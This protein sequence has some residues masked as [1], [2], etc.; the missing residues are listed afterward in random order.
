MV[1]IKE[2]LQHRDEWLSFI[3]ISLLCFACYS[4]YTVVYAALPAI[5][6]E[7]HA[8]LSLLQSIEKIYFLMICALATIMGMLGD[9]Y[10]RKRVLH[11]GVGI[12]IIASVIV[13]S[14]PNINC[15]YW[16]R[17]IQGIGAAI[18]FPLGLA[19]L[20]QSFPE[21]KQDNA[22]IDLENGAGLVFILSPGFVGLILAYLSWRWVFF[23]NISIVLLGYLLCLKSINESH[24]TNYALSLNIK[25]MLSFFLG[26]I[27]GFAA[28]CFAGTIVFLNSLYVQVMKSQPSQLFAFCILHVMPIILIIVV[29]WVESLIA[30]LSFIKTFLSTLI[31][32]CLVSLAQLFSHNYGT[33]F[34]IIFLFILL[35]LMWIRNNTISIAFAQRAVGNECISITTGVM[36]TMFNIG[37][38]TA[39]SHLS[40]RLPS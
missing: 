34:Y 38:A 6:E 5:Q 35:K 28:G 20:P 32:V 8:N 33:L 39:I 36:V 22:M 2:L 11:V 10:G 12:F 16:G 19:L 1:R 15:L 37:F 26:V 25:S 9:I 3:G 21:K 31:V 7:F 13:G 40:T 17:L 24:E 14:A 30:R 18:I 4:N 23:I 29:F 27:F